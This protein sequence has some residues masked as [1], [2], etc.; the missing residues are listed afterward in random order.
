MIKRLHETVFNK[1]L[2][3]YYLTDHIT[4]G[5]Y[6]K[7]KKKQLIAT[8]EFHVSSIEKVLIVK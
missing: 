7:K 3:P 2:L 6:W 4:C 8:S 1:F 5:T